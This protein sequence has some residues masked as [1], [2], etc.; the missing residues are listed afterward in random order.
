MGVSAS[1][2]KTESI[3]VISVMLN[4]AVKVMLEV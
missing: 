4:L 1:L 3:T 2:E